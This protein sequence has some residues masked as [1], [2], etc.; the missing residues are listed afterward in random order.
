MTAPARKTR[1]AGRRQAIRDAHNYYVAN[2]Y[3]ADEVSV[4]EPWARFQLTVSEVATGKP[5]A[6]KSTKQ[7]TPAEVIDLHGSQKEPPTRTVELV[8]ASTVEMERVEWL[9]PMWIPKRSLTLLAGREGL[10]KST[11]A[12]GFA[13]M[14]TRG[15]F[16]VEPGTAPIPPTNVAYLA[17]EDSLGMTVKPRLI[18]AGADIDRVMF[19]EVKTEN[20]F[21]G[22]LT[23][24]ND[25][26]QLEQA[27][28]EA[29]V[30]FVILDAAKSAMNPKLDGYKDD[31]VRQ[32]LEPLAALA[33]RNNIVVLGITHFGKADGRDTGKLMMGSVAWSQIARSVISVARD[34]NGTLYVSNTKGNLA[35]RTLNMT[36]EV[37]TTSVNI[38]PHDSTEVGRIVWGS[39]TD[40]KATDLLTTVDEFEAEER[41]ETEQWLTEYLTEHGKSLRQKV[42][43]DARANGFKPR[44]VQ[45]AF[46][47]LG[48]V[49]S[50]Q[51]TEGKPNQAVWG[52]PEKE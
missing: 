36:A 43:R 22:A 13:A 45:R 32:F 18:A 9:Y 47:R 46:K 39:E 7:T 51:S 33:E 29:K 44:T 20:G 10:G 16:P 50:T 17:T 5:D 23:L 34:E 26:R 4:M 41:N 38:G 52:L 30:G 21:T 40:V 14:A 35:P 27:L 1:I 28:V 19:V 24:P 12:C 48:G 15:T 3:P 8:P 2:D 49:S 31:H 11:I 42:L 37:Q 6:T 25:I